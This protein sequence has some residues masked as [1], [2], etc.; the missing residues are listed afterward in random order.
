LALPFRSQ[1]LQPDKSAALLGDVEPPAVPAVEILSSGTAFVRRNL[2]LILAF[3][4]LTIGSSAAYL[5][6]ATPRFTAE[7]V[8]YIEKP[9]IRPVQLE[10]ASSE[11][12]VDSRTVDSQVEILKS[13]AIAMAVVK[14]LQLAENTAFIGAR[15]A[16]LTAEQD[17]MRVL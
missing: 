16:G 11:T 3:L 17:A 8:L 5:L 9:Q 12:S 1:M 15:T 7:A 2:R 13:D 10:P 14:S 4:A 6:F